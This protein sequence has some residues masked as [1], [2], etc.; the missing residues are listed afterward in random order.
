MHGAGEVVILGFEEDALAFDIDAAEVVLAP[1]IVAVVE[2]V[3]G[4]D[5]RL[6]A[7]SSGAAP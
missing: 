4:L 6:V 2:D 3:E 7:S 5:S 1:R